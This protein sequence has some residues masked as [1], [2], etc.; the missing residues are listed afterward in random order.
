MSLEIKTMN[1]IS[2]RLVSLLLGVLLVF[3]CAKDGDPGPEGPHGEKGE[4]G[5]AGAV[6][7]TYSDWLQ[8]DWNLSDGSTYKAH[9]L[10]VGELTQDFIDQ[11]GVLLVFLRDGDFIY[12]IPFS[13]GNDYLY[14]TIS[15]P[16]ELLIYLGTN[17]GASVELFLA[18][19][20]Y[21]YVLIP[22]ES[23]VNG[24]T[25]SPDPTNYNEV[26]EYYSIPK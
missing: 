3:G 25:R 5:E 8:I 19:G 11:G 13:A 9:S 26:V 1:K 17:D 14:F 7:I 21:R 24:R 12:P 16:N 10:E 18:E 2:K 6:D 22:G 15:L 20:E 23:N 4:K